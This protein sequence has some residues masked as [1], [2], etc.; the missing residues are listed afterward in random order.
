MSRYARLIQPTARHINRL[1]IG[2][3]LLLSIAAFVDVGSGFADAARKPLLQAGKKTIYERVLTQPGTTLRD[4]AGQTGAGKALPA[5]SILYVY[6]RQN[7]GG[8][9]W[10]EVG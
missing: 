7:A 8:A 3:L 4:T 9:S 5:M 10:I 1:L 2:G 6:A